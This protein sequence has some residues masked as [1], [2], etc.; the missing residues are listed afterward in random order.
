MAVKN[1]LLEIRLKMGFKK[2]KDFADYLEVP[3]N[4]YNRYENNTN[5]PSIEVLY[6]ISK[7]LGC[8]LDELVYDEEEP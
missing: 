7:K 8:T 6:R 5:Q 2:Q 3:R 1:R 4:Q